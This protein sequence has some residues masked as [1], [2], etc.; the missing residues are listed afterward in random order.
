MYIICIATP[1]GVDTS[2]QFDRSALGGPATSSQGRDPGYI[3]RL[4]DKER[5]RLEKYIHRSNNRLSWDGILD[6]RKVSSLSKDHVDANARYSLDFEVNDSRSTPNASL[7]RGTKHHNLSASKF[8]ENQNVSVEYP[9][10]KSWISLNPPEDEEA[11]D[12]ADGTMLSS[13]SGSVSGRHD[14]YAQLSPNSISNLD[15]L[16]NENKLSK[17]LGALELGAEKLRERE[18]ERDKTGGQRVT[19]WDDHSQSDGWNSTGKC[20]SLGYFCAQCLLNSG[21]LPVINSGLILY[22]IVRSVWIDL[23]FNC[24]TRVTTDNL[25]CGILH[26]LVMRRV[27]IFCT[28]Q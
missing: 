8:D 2:S 27:L 25:K 10:D 24:V 23:C 6:G 26:H 15:K 1:G 13:K 4:E 19:Q 22:I 21:L 28:C 16:D 20:W 12:Y 7:Q 9:P 18:R 17:S 5:K 3:Q 14:S 11:A